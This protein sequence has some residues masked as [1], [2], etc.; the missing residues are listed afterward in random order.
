MSA[1]AKSIFRQEA[2]D[3]REQPGARGH[4]LHLE[5]AW[6]RRMVFLLVLAAVATI[7]FAL[8]FRIHEYA[9]GPALVR[10]S[11][12]RAVAPTRAGAVESILV[13]PGQVVS[14]GAPLVRLHDAEELA[15]L[16]RIDA[17]MESILVRLL[18]EPAKASFKDA[19]A[20]LAARR[21][22]AAARLRDRVI[23]APSDGIV[24]DVR[25]RHQQHVMPGDAIVTVTPPN[26]PIG[27]VAV[28][29]GRYRPSLHPGQTL[30]FS[31]D[32][33]H[34]EYQDVIVERVGAEVIGA[35]EAR[36]FLALAESVPIEGPVVLVQGRL[37]REFTSRG[38]VFRYSHG[39]TG[40]VDVRM[41]AQSLALTLFPWL[42]EVGLR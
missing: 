38:E 34:Y 20:G 17:E 15:E 32:G 2:I 27:I 3:Y 33:T 7:T 12:E 1:S 22:Q 5:D 35:A 25:V 26:S 16:A 10:L 23:V 6:S 39:L 24:S 41:R 8:T 19:M 14:R 18:R 4:P 11:D 42:R 28:L 37:P 9:S 29:P 31:L 40:K 21:D 36:R 13:E 30:R